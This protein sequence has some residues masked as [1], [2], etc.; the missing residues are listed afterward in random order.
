MPQPISRRVPKDDMKRICRAT[1]A[2]MV[3]SLGDM[4]GG[5]TFESSWLGSAA[6]AAEERVG[7]ADMVV[8]RGC[9]GS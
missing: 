2:T 1:G 4:D 7:D 6:S 8:L 3:V 5:E 9:K